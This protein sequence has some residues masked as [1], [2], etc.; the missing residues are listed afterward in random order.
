MGIKPQQKMVQAI[1]VISPPKDVKDL[2]KFLGMVQYYRD[3]WARC[4]EV[5]APLTSLVG[6]CAHTKVTRANKTKK[7]PWYWDTVH[8]KAFDDVKTTIAKD[9]VLAY[10]D[11]S[12]EFEIYTDA[13]S[14]QLGSVI[15]QVQQKYSVTELELLAI[16]KTLK[17]FKGML[18]G[19]RL[20]V[21]TD[22]KNLIQDMLG[23]T[24][25]RVYQWKLLLEECGPEIV[26]IKGTHNTVTDAISRLDIGPIPSEHENW[27]TFTK[28]WCYF[29]MQ[30]ENS[31]DTSAY[32]EEMNLVFANRSEEDVIYPLIV[33][34]IAEAQK[35]DA[36]LKTMKDQY[37]TQ[38]VES[39]EL[40]CKDRKMIIPKDLQRRAVSWYHHYL[41]H[42]GHTRLE[43]TLRAAM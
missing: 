5:L 37:S 6:E 23:L 9:V 27:M 2:R 25:D 13:S 32:Q 35:L 15:T 31:I 30:E 18:W 1:L 11:Y 21:Y 33:R 4:S 36:S 29:T 41:Q 8:Q 22:H 24:S 40:L 39:T 3:L 17:E 10:P 28:Y 42:P 38:L 26:Y 14:K 7:R 19:Q 43:E 16:V 34:E 12:R 20:K